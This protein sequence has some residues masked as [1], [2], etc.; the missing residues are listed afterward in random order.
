MLVHVTLI[1]EVNL[2]DIELCDV[3]LYDVCLCDIGLCDTG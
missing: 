2:F 1:C 3:G